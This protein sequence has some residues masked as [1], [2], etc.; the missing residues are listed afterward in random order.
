MNSDIRDLATWARSQ[1]WKV[2]D[3]ASGYTQFF[4]PSGEYVARYPATPS[5]PRRRMADLKVALKNAGL[6]IPPPSK[7]EQRAMRRTS[8]EGA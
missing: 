4:D 6:R 1:G 8:M 3:T 2:E 7:K 5:N